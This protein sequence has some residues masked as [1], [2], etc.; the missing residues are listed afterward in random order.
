MGH[1]CRNRLESVA[2]YRVIEGYISNLSLQIILQSYPL[3]W[4]LIRPVGNKFLLETISNSPGKLEIEVSMA[5]HLEMCQ[6]GYTPKFTNVLIDFYQISCDLYIS[7]NSLSD[8][9][10]IM[11]LK[12]DLRGQIQG[13]TYQKFSFTHFSYFFHSYGCITLATNIVIQTLMFTSYNDA[14]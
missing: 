8:C 14:Y 5:T 7:K 4:L 2:T 3:A 1:L 10:I 11:T 12:F 9:E 13:Q 6:Y